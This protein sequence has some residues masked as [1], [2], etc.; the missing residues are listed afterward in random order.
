MHTSKHYHFFKTFQKTKVQKGLEPGWLTVPLIQEAHTKL[1]VDIHEDAGKVRERPAY[2]VYKDEDYYHPM[3][4]KLSALFYACIDHH[5]MHIEGLNI[6]ISQL[7]KVLCNREF[8]ENVHDLDNLH[9]R[10]KML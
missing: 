1:L 6:Y 2:T 8:D 4:D 9:R 3:P 5:N 10:S 7:Q